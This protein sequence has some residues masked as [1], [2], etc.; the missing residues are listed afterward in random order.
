MG[1]LSRQHDVELKVG[2][3]A[4]FVVFGKESS[5]ARGSF[6]SRKTTQ[7][8]VYDPGHERITVFGGRIVSQ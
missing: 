2:D 6:R 8:L 7:E 5:K 4:D 1:R 3:R